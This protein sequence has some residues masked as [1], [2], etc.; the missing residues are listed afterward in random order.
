MQRMSLAI[1]KKF[2]EHKYVC[3]S[4]HFT[5]YLWSGIYTKKT[6]RH[7]LAGGVSNFKLFSELASTRG[8]QRALRKQCGS[9][10]GLGHQFIHCAHQS[11]FECAMRS[12]NAEYVSRQ[13]V[14]ILNLVLLAF[15]FSH[16]NNILIQMV[17]HINQVSSYKAILSNLITLKQILQDL[18][19]T[20]KGYI[21][22]A[23]LVFQYLI[24]N[25]LVLKS[26]HAHENIVIIVSLLKDSKGHLT[27]NSCILT[28]H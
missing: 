18:F 1:H 10:S 13:C 20:I 24:S 7:L 27:H 9:E 16:N 2:R 5:I 15:N 25:N 21:K 4:S 23:S 14:L 26:R 28:L 6:K 3:T 11:L 8:Q 22:L 17:C 19:K 12:L